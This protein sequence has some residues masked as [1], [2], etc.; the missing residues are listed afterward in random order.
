MQE[1]PVILFDGVC[2]LC[3]K[4]VQ[5]V[6]NH[7]K[8]ETL[9][10][11]SLQSEYG[12]NILKQ[13][14]IEASKFDSIVLVSKNNIY[15]K[16]TAVLKISKHLKFPYNLL[17]I[18]NVIPTVIRDMFYNII[19]K[20]RFSIFGKSETCYIPSNNLKERFIK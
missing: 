18:L 17:V 11:A 8:S 13:N 16:S 7:E 5:F 2:N 6:L 9:F 12:Q 14:R 15:F 19:S 20:Y 4:S 10:F 3:S 1:K